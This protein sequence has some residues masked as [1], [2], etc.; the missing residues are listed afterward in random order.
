[1]SAVPSGVPVVQPR[2]AAFPE[3]MEASGG[4]VVYE[5]G[6]PAALADALEPLLLDR[7]KARALGEAGRRA[8]REKFNAEQMA[9]ETVDAYREIIARRQPVLVAAG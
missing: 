8:V 1:M 6:G 3:L 9:R 2:V 5:P 7:E 4:G